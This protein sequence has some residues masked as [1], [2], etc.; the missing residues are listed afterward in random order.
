MGGPLMQK[1]RLAGVHSSGHRRLVDRDT[2]SLFA[3][4]WQ[5]KRISTWVRKLALRLLRL[6]VLDLVLR[7][8]WFWLP[9]A[10]R[11]GGGACPSS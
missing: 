9:R 2:V 1:R 3:V 4:A 6:P 7:R 11:P 8:G 10:L 5:L